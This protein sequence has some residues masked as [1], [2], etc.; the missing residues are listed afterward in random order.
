MLRQKSTLL[1]LVLRGCLC[2]LAVFMGSVLLIF[3]AFCAVC[4]VLFVFVPFPVSNVANVSGLSIL[5]DPACL[6]L[7]LLLISE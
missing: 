2:T 1:L 3:L 4:F 7:R 5:D 6:L